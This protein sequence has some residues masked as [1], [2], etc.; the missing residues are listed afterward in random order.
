MKIS[1]IQSMNF[2]SISAPR[3]NSKA[4]T[5]PIQKNES[6]TDVMAYMNNIGRQ[7]MIKPNIQKSMA[8]SFTG[9]SPEAHN[10]ETIDK[11]VKI[12]KDPKVQKIAISG[13]TSPDGD[14]FGTTF[15]MANL[16]NQATGKK[17]DVFVFGDNFPS[18]YDYLNTTEIVIGYAYVIFIH[19]ITYFMPKACDCSNN[20][21]DNTL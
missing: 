12:M 2:T 18:H 1:A 15:A 16:I 10:K 20:F 14:S 5:S 13:H 6:K 11:M 3:A 17:V 19:N 9:W 8:V 4:V 21:T 7:A